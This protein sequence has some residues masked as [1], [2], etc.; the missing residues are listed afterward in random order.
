MIKQL[1]IETIIDDLNTLYNNRGAWVYDNI[2]SLVKK[3]RPLIANKEN[4]LTEKDI[5]LITY[6]DNIQ[7]E[8]NT[9][10]SMLKKFVDTYCLPEINST[11]ILPFCPYTSDDGFS[12]TDYF[13]IDKELGTW[14]DIASLSNNSNLMF[15]AVVNHMSKSSKWFQSYLAQEEGFQDFFTSVDP[16]TDLSKVVRPRTLPL[17]T[18]FKDKNGIEKFVW[19]TFS[20]DQV[21]LNYASPEVFIAVLDVLLFYVSRGAK[22]IRLDAIAFLWKTIGTNC[23]HLEET[24][25]I[26]K[27]YKKVIQ[28]LTKNVSIITETNVPHEENISYFGNDNNEA[29]LVYNFTLAPLLAYSIMKGDVNV[30]TNWAKSLEFPSDKVCFFNFTASHDGIGMR[31]LQNIISDDEIAKLASLAEKNGGYVSY[32]NNEDGSQSPYELNCNYIDFLS[33]ST[34]TDEV[35]IHKMLL[36]QAVMISMPGVPGIYFHSLVGSR[37]YNKGVEESGIKRRV[38]REK[39]NFDSLE[40]ELNTQ[41]SLRNKVFTTYKQLLSIRTKETAFNPYGEATYKNIN[42]NVFIIK[43]QHNQETIFTI[44]N[45]SNL[46][47]KIDALAVNVF[48][49]L[50]KKVVDESVWEIAPY[51]FN[52]YKK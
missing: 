6:G 28:S 13:K 45:F 32:K 52:W 2:V 51:Q 8:G 41:G 12:V 49:L 42:N 10:L 24:H 31:P 30:L 22:L 20:E 47:V 48:D 33:N 43:R 50:N 34:E 23:L 14:D 36:T 16:K 21:D 38:N 27:L 15:D 39:L 40:K 7:K 37:N 17:L 3:Y 35:R 18:P 44:Y 29:D 9:H 26:I 5:V 19:T 11:H 46:P 1:E 4:S 25:T